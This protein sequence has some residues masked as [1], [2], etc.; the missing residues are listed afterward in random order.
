MYARRHRTLPRAF[1][2]VELLVVIAIVGLMLAMLLPATQY[3]REAARRTACQSQ[4][5]QMGVA[6]QI[7]H[8]MACSTITVTYA[9]P[10]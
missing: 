7:H 6:L 3:A 8:D 9:F 2:L 10:K 5:R 1:T 4:L